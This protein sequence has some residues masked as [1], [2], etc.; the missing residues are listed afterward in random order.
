MGIDSSDDVEVLNDQ[1]QSVSNAFSICSAPPVSSTLL[2]E[3]HSSTDISHL[4]S[5]EI[6]L[7]SIYNKV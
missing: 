3:H 5:Y 7:L 2:K 1:K 4:Q 6:I